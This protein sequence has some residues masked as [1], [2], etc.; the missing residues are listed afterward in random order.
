GAMKGAATGDRGAGPDQRADTVVEDERERAA[1]RGAGQR[2]SDRRES[3]DE[4]RD[5]QR[6]QSP[7]FESSLGVSNTRVRRQRN[8]AERAQDAIAVAAAEKEPHVI[9]DQ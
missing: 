6:L 4:L 2:R 8:A 1:S 9:G 7:S 3:G 5:Q